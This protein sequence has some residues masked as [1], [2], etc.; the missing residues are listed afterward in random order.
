MNIKHVI[1][2]GKKFLQENPE[3]AEEVN[4]LIQLCKDNIEDGE[5]VENECNLCIDSIR[6]LIDVSN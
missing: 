2:E 1:E 5:S 6:Q 4:D 3:F